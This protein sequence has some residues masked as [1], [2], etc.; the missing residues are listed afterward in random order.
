MKTL[1]LDDT[2]YK[3][4][5]DGW[6]LESS[7]QMNSGYR[8][9]TRYQLLLYPNNTQDGYYCHSEQN[10]V[11]DG[12]NEQFITTM[13]DIE[14]TGNEFYCIVRKNDGLSYELHRFHGLPPLARKIPADLLSNATV[15]S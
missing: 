7:V 2:T 4:T 12:A 8:E 6:I 3:C 14:E 9:L 5:D 10:H 1:T 11:F 15:I 13:I